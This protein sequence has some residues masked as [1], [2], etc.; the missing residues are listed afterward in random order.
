VCITD[1]IVLLTYISW[2]VEFDIDKTCKAY[3]LLSQTIH[4]FLH[5]CGQKTAA[6]YLFTGAKYLFTYSLY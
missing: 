5:Q 1:D 3:D 2:R 4:T 6:K